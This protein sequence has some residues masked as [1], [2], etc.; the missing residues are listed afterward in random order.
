MKRSDLVKKRN[1]GILGAI[2]GL[3]ITILSLD[4]AVDAQKEIMRLDQGKLD[5]VRLK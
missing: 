1:L 4:T 2:I 5:Q 3:I